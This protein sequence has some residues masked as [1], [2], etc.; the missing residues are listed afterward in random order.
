MQ[1]AVPFDDLKILDFTNEMGGY[2]TKLFADLGATVLKVEPLTGESTRK[3]SPFFHDI[4]NDETSL[5]HF[6]L[7]TNKKSMTLD[8]ETATGQQI[9]KEL[10]KEYDVIVENFLPDY[11]PSL[12][13]GYQ[14]LKEINPNIIFTS[15]TPFGQDGPYKHYKA[16]DIVGVAMGG[17]MYLGGYPDTPP[18]RP[19]GNQSY[20]A[21]SLFGAVGTLLAIYARDLNHIGQH[22]DVSMQESI[23]LALENAVQL[24]DLE[25]TVRKRIGSNRAQAGWGLYPCADGQVYLISAG[26]AGSNAWNNLVKWLAD[27]HIE[28]WKA[29]EDPKWHDLEWRVSDE[30]IRQ[31]YD[32]FTTFS[33]S[34]NKLQLYE[35]GQSR[36][37]PIC[38]VN[39]PKD[40]LENPQLKARQFFKELRHDHLEAT[41]IYPGAPYIFTEMEWSL[42]NPAPKKGS[43]N[44]EVLLNLGYTVED[45]IHLKE[46]GII[47]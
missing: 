11:L 21:A 15:I 38:P 27:H 4:P 41:V 28:G 14:Q 17:L 1:P 25:R 6:F 32:I 34:K 20:F 30:G 2:C 35:E 9:V 16:T 46:A 8:I 12:G 3:L 37:I 18:V 26:M 10:I 13:L 24:Y 43:H 29:L 19:Y 45:I 5:Y 40:V 33:M 23:A 42:R 31:F 36:N 47:S 44:Q 7:N 39:N 22:V